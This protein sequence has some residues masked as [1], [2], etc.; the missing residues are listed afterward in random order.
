MVVSPFCPGLNVEILV[1]DQLLQEYDDID[2]SAGSANTVIKYIEAQSH[3][4]FAV[5]ARVNEDFIF[6]IGDI[7]VRTTVDGRIFERILIAADELFWPEGL[8]VNGKSCQIGDR[9]NALQKF[10]F[11]ALQIGKLCF[12]ILLR[13]CG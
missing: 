8:V 12:T 2:Q 4:H 9:T 11:S 10:Q 13:L 7:E 1:D 5:R 3:A 6:P